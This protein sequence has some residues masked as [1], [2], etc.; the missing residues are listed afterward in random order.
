MESKIWFLLEGYVK[1][2][3]EGVGWTQYI[4]FWWLWWCRKMQ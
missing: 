4:A 1:P 2:G 3:R